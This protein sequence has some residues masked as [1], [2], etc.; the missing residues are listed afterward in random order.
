[1]KGNPAGTYS[2]HVNGPSC[3]IFRWLDS[4]AIDV[5]LQN[6]H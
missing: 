5:D 4:A 6:Y 3:I 2:V 1:M